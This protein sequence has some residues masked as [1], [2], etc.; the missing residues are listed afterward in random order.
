[1]T[2]PRWLR[3][4]LVISLALNLGVLG[5]IGYR[6]IQSSGVPGASPGFPGLVDYLDLRDEQ[7]RDWREAESH[8]LAQFEPRASEIRE[9][10]DRLIR[11]MFA[12]DPDRA[13]I[14]SDRARI[15]R[16]QEEQQRLVVEQ[17]LRERAVLDA[18]QR[19]RLMQL[20]LEQSAGQS[21]PETLHRD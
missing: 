12:D 1:M 10:R 3:Y 7:K 16:L 19:E 5:A 4:V 6:A 21:G 11:A 2:N 15:A 9:L 8:F 13:A 20:L 18:A 17:L 14:E